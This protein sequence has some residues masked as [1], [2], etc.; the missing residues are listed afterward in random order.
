[1]SDKN[2][3]THREKGIGTQLMVPLFYNLQTSAFI[4]VLLYKYLFYYVSAVI[5]FNSVEKLKAL[6]NLFLSFFFLTP[7]FLLKNWI[8]G[9]HLLT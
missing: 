4:W 2:I 3:R 8:M 1:M 7:D 5:L 9:L 6:K